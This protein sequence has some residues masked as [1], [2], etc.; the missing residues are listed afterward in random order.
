MF[1]TQSV[2]SSQ[3]FIPTPCYIPGPWF[4]VCSLCIILIKKVNYEMCLYILAE[5]STSGNQKFRDSIF[6]IT[7]PPPEYQISTTKHPTPFMHP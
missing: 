1:Y 7:L 4:A 6:S 5:V 2:V 3:H